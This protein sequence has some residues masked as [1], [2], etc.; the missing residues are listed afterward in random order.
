MAGVDTFEEGLRRGLVE[1]LR[2]ADAL[3][4]DNE[5]VRSFSFSSPP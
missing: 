5:G 4:D 3:D 1:Y 2:N